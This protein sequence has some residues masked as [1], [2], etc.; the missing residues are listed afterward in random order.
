VSLRRRGAVAVVAA[1]VAGVLVL[2]VVSSGANFN[3]PSA[4]PSNKISADSA[5]NYVHLYAQA[6]DPSGLTGYAV[7][8]NSAPAVPAATGA[9]A[10]LAVALGGN[11]NVVAQ[12]FTRVLTLQAPATLPAGASPLVVTAMLAPDPASL[13][14]PLSVVTFS[15]LDGS[16]ASPTATLTAGAKKQLNLVVR[17]QG[18]S[19]IGVLYRPTLTLTVTFPGYVGTFLNYVVPITVWDGNGAGP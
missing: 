6:S 16:G 1:A 2:P 8:R 18:F 17:T 19:G 4:N 13:L 11:K 3:S 9:D 5:D 10:T 15:N 7:K 12:T 14:Q